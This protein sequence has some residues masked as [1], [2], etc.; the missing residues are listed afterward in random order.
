MYSIN[1]DKSSSTHLRLQT[2]GI[3]I[4]LLQIGKG[5]SDSNIDPNVPPNERYNPGPDSPV[6]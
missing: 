4:V 1:T 6:Q 2:M 5:R 3:L